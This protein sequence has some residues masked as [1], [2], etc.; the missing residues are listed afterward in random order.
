M[1]CRRLTDLPTGEQP[2]AAQISPRWG[3]HQGRADDADG[4]SP[5]MERPRRTA[6]YFIG[7]SAIVFGNKSKDARVPG[8]RC[9]IR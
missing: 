6:R 5:M 1:A 9:C 3:G 4:M 7:V 2:M 8:L